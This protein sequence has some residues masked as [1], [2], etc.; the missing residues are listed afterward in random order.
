[1]RRLAPT[2]F[3][4][5]LAAALAIVAISSSALA[6]FSATGAGEVAAPVTKLS[7]P[8]ITGATPAAGGTV[9]LNW[10]AV[11]APGTGTVQY[12]VSRDSGAP[13][14]DCPA[15][16]SPTTVLTCT[17]S[18]LSVAT[19]SYT[20]TA[21]W[22]S[23]TSVSG[24]S[25]ANVT[26]GPAT[27]FTITA[28]SNTPAAA[29]T[30]NLTITAKD[31]NGSTVPTYTGSHSLTFS[32][33]SASPGGTTPT[34]SDASGT[35][36]PFGT[37]IPIT[38]TAGVAAAA[39]GANG[40]M[41][42]YKSG[43]TSV[44][45][46][47]GSLTTPTPLAVT[48]APL[49]A[50][51][52]GIT[53]ASNTP[54]A[55]A[56]DNLTVTAQDTYGNTATTYT[57]SH[58]LIFSGASAS[59]GGNAP[60][61]VNGSG[62]TI[63]F[64]TA[65]A[66]TFTAGIASVASSKNGVL[67]IYNAGA[68]NIVATEGSLT[69]P[70]PLALTVTQLT[71]TKFTI[72]AASNSPAAGAT[73]NLTIT[74]QD[75]YGNTATAYAGSHSLVFSGASTSPGGNAPTVSNASGTDIAFGTAT[76]I[77]F[78][79][80]VAVASA[81]ANGKMTLYKSGATNV[82]ATEGSV[83]T[84]TALA[85]TVAPLG[86]T[87]FTITAASN[88]PAA[89]ATDN[90][91]ITAADTYGNAIP[92]YTGSHSLTFSGA[93]ASPGGTTPTVSDASG[94]DTPFGT[95]IPITFTAGVA[96]AA[97]GANGEMTLYKSGVTSVNA[98]DGTLATPTPLAVTVAPGTAINLSLA[99]ATPTPVAAAADNLTI[100]AQDT[101][102]N[103]ATAYTGS[104][105]LTFSGAV[106]S[107]SGALPTVANSSGT[108]TNFGTATALTFSAGI[109]TV[110]TTKN[111]VMKLNKVGATSV[112]VSDG[113]I[114]AAAPLALTVTEG[115][116]ARLA[117]VN[118]SSSAGSVASTCLFTCAVTLLGNSGTFTAN[119]AVTDSV[120]NT[121]SAIGTGHTVKVT[122]SGGAITGGSLTIEATG[123]AVST[124][125]FTYT[126]PASGT[127]SNTI[128]AATSGGTTYTSATATA[129]R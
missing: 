7:A 54:A 18:G 68:A 24:I 48:V 50:T 37:A 32:G 49:T 84:P 87:R 43:A 123:P 62:T 9:T 46:T 33:A 66:L 90:L 29:A 21:V 41:T 124:A 91:T 61:I 86:L 111:G 118:A 102:G 98:T 69:T 101:Y 115:A 126:A 81:G 72:T 103:T 58:S 4:G 56:T 20:V 113:T 74:A 44:T 76:P 83:T 65:T 77:T 64:G 51:K 75:T 88:T 104:K 11:S 117:L 17:D 39:S 3:T 22:R 6:Y 47:E 14:G 97:S 8:T 96:A 82:T 26:I 16:G 128:T 80:G 78:T 52:F 63:N 27:K 95:A 10:S 92:T 2:G 99:A 94:T 59:P 23:W 109:A 15:S 42:L 36:T 129:S 67:K 100:T 71:A 93:S 30:D 25:T 5:I 60:T 12:Y 121:V 73:D 127:F 19:H 55:G 119:V 105:S 116:A 106:A 112:T 110:A 79:A 53:A 38:F 57:G 40:E 120:G 107:P 35:D 125:K 1:V 31:A 108:A 34:V 89:G 114:S 70:T 45:A 13:A 122:T 28:A 85:V